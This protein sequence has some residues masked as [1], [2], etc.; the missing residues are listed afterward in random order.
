M[1]IAIRVWRA[2]GLQGTDCHMDG[3]SARNLEKSVWSRGDGVV[4]YV[5]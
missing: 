5:D 2:A 4:V 1:S 3:R